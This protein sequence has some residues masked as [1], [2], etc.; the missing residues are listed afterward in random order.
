[1]N[2]HA[3][4]PHRSAGF[5]LV[6]VMVALV[7]CS[8]GLLGL[9]KMESLAL[10]STS[11]AG[12]RSLVA[13]Y[14]GS[15]A[16]MMHAN[17]GYWAAG[18]AP[19]STTI[20]GSSGVVT[21]ANTGSPLPS[22]AVCTTAGAGSCA[23]PAQASYDLSQWGGLTNGG[24][25]SLLPN[26]FTSITCTTTAPPVTCTIS[27]KWAENA[28]AINEQQTT[29]NGNGGTIASLALPTYTLFVQP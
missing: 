21:I 9:A 19:A 25:L 29:D 5:S 17:Q 10:A 4:A 14:A 13:I 6:E 23:P 18:L 1:M 12:T 11:V 20:T 3:R 26:Y 8:I 7:V 22:G 27:I 24:L 2:I 28:V 15:L 16:S